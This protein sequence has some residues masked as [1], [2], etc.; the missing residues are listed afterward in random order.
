MKTCMRSTN[1]IDDSDS[2]LDGDTAEF[3]ELRHDNVELDDVV[4]EFRKIDSYDNYSISNLGNARN[5][6]TGRIMKPQKDTGG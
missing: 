2:N 5:D 6:K 3:E 4:E 1:H